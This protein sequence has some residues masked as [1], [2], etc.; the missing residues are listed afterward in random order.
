MCGFHGVRLRVWAAFIMMHI[1]NLNT[2]S[3]DGLN[4]QTPEPIYGHTTPH[5]PQYKVDGVMLDALI[6]VRI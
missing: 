6:T 4:I 2:C 1:Q 3:V 5:T